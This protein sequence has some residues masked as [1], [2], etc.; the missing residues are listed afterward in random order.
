MTPQ[1]LPPALSL[2]LRLQVRARWRRVGRGSKTLKGKLYLAAMIV[3]FSVWLGPTLAATFFMRRSDFVDQSAPL[4]QAL[5][6]SSLLLYC[7]ITLIATGSESGIAFQP[8]EVDLLFPA[9]FRRR[10]L[11]LYR[12]TGLALGLLFTSLMFSIFLLSHVRFWA[13]GFIGIALA[14]VFIQLVPIVLTLCIAIVG[15]RAYTR[16]RRLVLIVLAALI[17]AGIGEVA[18]RRV[19]GGVVEYAKNFRSTELGRCLL[20]PF[21]VFSRTMTADIFFPDFLGWGAGS[22]W[23]R[24]LGLVLRLDA[25]FLESSIAASQKLYQKI[26]RMRR[27]QCG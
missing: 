4:V 19:E 8:A 20:A 1:I 10:E 17:A 11:L 3:M 6:P 18:V 13:F 15:E 22:F 2:L 23:M 25:N 7:I 16:G 5:L 27:G 9:P 21:E 14:F 24:L 26:E 12:L